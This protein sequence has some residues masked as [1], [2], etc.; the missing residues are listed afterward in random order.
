MH[1]YE[2]AEKREREKYVATLL[3][4]KVNLVVATKQERKRERVLSKLLKGDTRLE[5][6]QLDSCRGGIKLAQA[7]W[8]H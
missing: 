2:A 8:W 4:C 7:H 1:V 5:A 3:P 6:E